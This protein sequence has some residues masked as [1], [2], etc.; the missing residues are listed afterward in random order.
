MSDTP[1]YD[2][3]CRQIEWCHQHLFDEIEALADPEE[4]LRLYQRIAR[5]NVEAERQVCEIRLRA[6][7][8]MRRLMRKGMDKA[9]PA[10]KR[11]A[12]RSA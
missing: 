10:P 3:A 12:R 1:L 4:R 2:E 11:R 7:R 6:D 9:A 5:Q 8:G